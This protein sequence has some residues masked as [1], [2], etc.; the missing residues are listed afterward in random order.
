M[1]NRTLVFDIETHSADLLYTMLPEE[2]VRLIGY[3]W[4][5]GPTVITTDLEEIREQIRSARCIIGHNIAAFD[6]P[7]V[8]GIGSDEP[9]QLAIEKRVYCTW[10]HAILVNPAP[11][12]YV[13]RLGKKALADSPEKMRRWFSLNE[14]AHQLGVAG[15]TDDLQA[16][17][18]EFGDPD[19]KGKEKEVSG[20]GRIPTDDDRYVAYLHGDV[21]SSEAVGRA[22]LRRGP[23]DA[24][25]LR[26]QEIAA[27]AA[28]ISANGLRLDREAAEARVS[29]LA[30]RREVIMTNLVERYDF[31]TEGK[32]PWATTEGKASIMAMLADHGITPETRKSWTK[33]KTG[34]LSL[35]G[36]TLKELTKGTEAEDIGVAIAELKG[37][38]SLAELALDTVHADG[39]AHPEI[40]MLQRSG[41]WSTTRPGLTVWTSRGPG[42]VEKAYYI[43][44]F[45]DEVLIAFDYSNADARMVAA[46]SGD[47]KFAERFLPGADGHMINAIAAWGQ[48]VVDTDPAGYRQR[49]K[50]PGHGWG[51]RIGAKKLA[52]STGMPLSEAKQFLDNLNKTYHKV[53]SWQDAASREARR[54][55]VMNDWG[56]RMPIEQGREFTQGPALKGQSG[57]REIVCDAIL[58]MPPHVLRRLKAQIHDEL[59]FSVPRANWEEWRDYLVDLMSTSFKPKVAGQR[60]DFPVTAG[61]PGANWFEATH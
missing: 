2:F 39:F 44:D 31:P 13:N 43:P 42:A 50:A 54:G 8:F 29:E 37:Q 23:L 5:G 53:V 60:I 26:E 30:A 1:S 61:P 58:R 45:D 52:L 14:Q 33:T 19:L 34:N 36:D 46:L 25:A 10:T 3:R 48:D 55:F 35:G 32:S 12:V 24:Y 27:R 11:Y 20:Y 38:R 56:R 49:A 59:I 22:L 18:R 17:A 4:V 9:L 16:L 6:L 51:Y 40:T 57:T 21:D 15:K 28:I 41:R 7:A 47:T